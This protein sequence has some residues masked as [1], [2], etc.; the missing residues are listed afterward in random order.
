MICNDKVRIQTSVILSPAQGTIGKKDKKITI[1]VM[2]CIVINVTIL[3][4]ILMV[5][6]VHTKFFN[7]FLIGL[8]HHANIDFCLRIKRIGS[9]ESF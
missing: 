1:I 9:G 8:R 2:I 5:P 7:R 4:I 3:A 6:Q